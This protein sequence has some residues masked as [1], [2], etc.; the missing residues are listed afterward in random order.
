M[1]DYDTEP[2]ARIWE[3]GAELWVRML[4]SPKYDNMGDGPAEPGER[5]IGNMAGAMASMIP[6]NATPEILEAFR[7]ALLKRMTDTN[8]RL[9]ERQSQHVD[10]GP[11]VLLSDSAAEAGLKMEF[12]WKTNMWITAS[13]VSVRN[14]YGAET[15]YHYPLEGGR[16]LVTT[17]NGSDI[18]KVIELVEGGSPQFAIEESQ[19]FISALADSTTKHIGSGKRKARKEKK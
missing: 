10:Y 6:N 5:F 2:S 9:Y 11:D 12:P 18:S 8:K 13:Y 15:V 4:R 16:W 17:L 7:C 14:G 3:R 19:S 1:S